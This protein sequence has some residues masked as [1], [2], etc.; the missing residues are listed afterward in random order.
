MS[1]QTAIEKYR[2]SSFSLRNLGDRFERLMQSFLRT[3]HQYFKKF[4]KFVTVLYILHIISYLHQFIYYY[5]HQY[6]IY[7]EIPFVILFVILFVMDKSR[8]VLSKDPNPRNKDSMPQIGLPLTDFSE[9]KFNLKSFA[10][11][12]T[13]IV[14]SQLPHPTNGCSMVIALDSGWGT[15]K[16]SFINMWTDRLEND[17]KFIYLTYN[18]WK[19]DDSRDALVPILYCIQSSPTL[20]TLTLKKLIIYIICIFLTLKPRIALTFV[21][22]VASV[23]IIFLSN[24]FFNNI[25]TSISFGAII[26]SLLWL[27]LDHPL[28]KWFHQLPERKNLFRKLINDIRGE[29]DYFL[30]CIDELDRC[31]P[32]FAIE[33]LEV[34]KHFF[35]LPNV[36]FV[37]SLDM[38]QLSKSIK[39]VYGDIDS[40]GYLQRFFDYICPLPEPE[41][42]NLVKFLKVRFDHFLNEQ[43]IKVLVNLSKPFRISLRT[44]NVICAVYGQFKRYTELTHNRD[45]QWDPD[46][47]LIYYETYLTLIALKYSNPLGYRS[48]IRNGTDF[49]TLSDII[50]PDAQKILTELFEYID[51]D[52]GKS[53]Y[54][55]KIAQGSMAHYSSLEDKVR[56]EVDRHFFVGDEGVISLNDK[57]VKSS[58]LPLFDSLYSYI[59]RNIDA[60]WIK[61][62][63]QFQTMHTVMRESFLKIKEDSKAYGLEMASVEDGGDSI[64]LRVK[65]DGTEYDVIARMNDDKGC[66]D[67]YVNGEYVQYLRY[68]NI[69]DFTEKYSKNQN[70][71]VGPHFIDE[72]TKKFRGDMEDAIGIYQNWDNW[73]TKSEDFFENF[74]KNKQT[75]D[76]KFWF[77][78]ITEIYGGS[79]GILTRDEITWLCELAHRLGISIQDL[80]EIC[81]V[82]N[83]FKTNMSFGN[84]RLKFYDTCKIVPANKD[85][86]QKFYDTY[87]TLI[88]MSQF[89]DSS[90]DGIK[91]DDLRDKLPFKYKSLLVNGT[92]IIDEQNDAL[93]EIYTKVFGYEDPKSGGLRSC[94]TEE[95]ASSKWDDPSTWVSW[96]PSYIDED[97]LK[98]QIANHFTDVKLEPCVEVNLFSREDTKRS[99]KRYRYSSTE[100]D[101]F[102]WEDQLNREANKRFGVNRY[103]YSSAEGNRFSWEIEEIINES[104]K[105]AKKNNYIIKIKPKKLDW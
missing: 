91:Q 105:L 24:I 97:E 21:S 5:L 70:T 43:D 95:V 10:D 78:V 20:K 103:R 29:H 31:R 92:N 100:G 16:T 57:E 98:R 36:I 15:G 45:L 89:K 61:A 3:Y 85:L 30:I 35:D 2:A 4:I 101:R 65:V 96:V 63:H 33:T 62:V 37:F 80:K 87:M 27:I 8:N 73:K 93:R 44:F 28:A 81:A 32:T 13:S 11:N 6:I 86:N 22:I 60:C 39:T 48:F 66:I 102:S 52:S 67:T 51:N 69:E 79:E 40:A 25:D 55:K 88:A 99:M 94:Y 42:D 12:L 19:N 38:N 17:P 9:D 90:Y 41:R 54:T 26:T 50:S 74:E 58:P 84:P 18:A 46:S 64:C 34:V 76:E 71:S 49:D 77:T 47:M 59:D 14:V 53:C 104:R 72:V 83:Q 82:Y 68:N 1:F 7:W 75:M 23:F 56:G